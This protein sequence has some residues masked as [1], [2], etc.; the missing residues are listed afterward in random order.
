VCLVRPERS[1]CSRTIYLFSQKS[2]NKI[3]ALICSTICSQAIL[4]LC[5][6]APLITLK[7]LSL[8][9]IFVCKCGC[10]WIS[11]ESWWKEW[12]IVYLGW[13]G[14]CIMSDWS[15][16]APIYKILYRKIPTVFFC[17]ISYEILY[18]KIPT[19][20]QSQISWSPE[21]SQ[22]ANISLDTVLDFAIILIF[23]FSI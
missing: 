13:F 14:R 15:S 18:R 8:L 5:F 10:E 6:L 1:D 12:C 20:N 21:I 23:R 3:L 16:P 22:R 17:S 19:N 4:I 7:S 11:T 2:S 9:A